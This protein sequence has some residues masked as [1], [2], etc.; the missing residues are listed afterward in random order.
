[1]HYIVGN[2]YLLCLQCLW[3]PLAFGLGATF[4]VQWELKQQGLMFSNIDVP[5]I[6]DDQLSFLAIVVIMMV[7]ALLYFVATWYIEG[8]YPGRYGVAKPWY[9]PFMPSYWYGKK[10][11]HANCGWL[12][13]SVAT[14]VNLQEDEQELLGGLAS[15]ICTLC[16]ASYHSD[17]QNWVRNAR[18]E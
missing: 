13:R 12:S 9:F 2:A 14:D 5:A 4:L 11:A 18:K 6:E 17:A 16:I 8:V 3:A 10:Y 1:M 15:Y 7:D